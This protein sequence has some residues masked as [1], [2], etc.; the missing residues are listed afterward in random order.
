VPLRDEQRR[1][2]A[3]LLA[4]LLVEAGRKREGVRSDGGFI[5]ALGGASDGVTSLPDGGVEARRA[6]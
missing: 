1:E 5:G 6:A 2:A 3:G 4:E